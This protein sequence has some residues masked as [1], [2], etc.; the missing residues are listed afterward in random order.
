[1]FLTDCPSCGIRELRGPRAI[2]LLVNT[3]RGI[4]VVFRCTGCGTSNVVEASRRPAAPATARV[5]A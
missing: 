1:M 3:D 5:A 4:D 2:E